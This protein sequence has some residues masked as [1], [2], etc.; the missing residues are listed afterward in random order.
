MRVESAKADL[1]R[2]YDWSTRAAFESVDTTREYALNHRNVQSFLRINGY[3]AT[4]SEVVAVIRRL[5]LD[6]D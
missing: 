1:S 2:R 5:D 6:A 3:Y 4:E